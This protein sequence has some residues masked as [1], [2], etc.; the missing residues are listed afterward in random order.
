[1]GTGAVRIGADV[2]HAAPSSLRQP[3][4][5]PRSP[6]THCDSHVRQCEVVS[7]RDGC[8]DLEPFVEDEQTVFLNMI[9]P[10]RKATTQYLREESDDEA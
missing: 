6:S 10:S 5:L 7:D 4:R 8:V 2:R 1:M 9:I 3:D